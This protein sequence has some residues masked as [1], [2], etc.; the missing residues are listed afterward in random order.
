[1]SSR[2]LLRDVFVGLAIAFVALRLAG[3]E[4][5]DQSVDAYAYWSTRD[6][7]LYEGSAVGSL[8]SYLYSPAFAMLLA[9]LT[10]LPWDLFN[11]GWT[12]MNLAILWWLFG[13]W[14]LVA[15]AFLPI[16]IE[17]VAGNVHLLYAAVAVAG[18]RYPAVWIIPIVTKLTP[19]IGLLWFAFR[20]EWRNL[21]IALAATA[22]VVAISY[23]LN[24]TAWRQWVDL[25]VGSNP[26]P[27]TPGFFI[28]IPLPI[29][30]AI[31]VAV[32]AWGARTER[33][34]VFPVA[35]TLALPLLW[36]N[37]LATLAALGPTLISW[38]RERRGRPDGVKPVDLRS[39][40]RA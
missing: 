40:S 22:A 37:G 31:A 10:W 17:I 27:P 19:G 21:A 20:R 35:M 2:R 33:P 38:L 28:P 5:W 4:P 39:A 36:L 9:P 32:L 25:L 23:L 13:R 29:R 16:P 24:P 34:W 7:T 26:A 6:G 8:G 15:L 30:L 14:S 1:V 18:L 11:A 3:V 12:A